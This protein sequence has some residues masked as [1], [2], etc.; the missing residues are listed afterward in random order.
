MNPTQRF[1]DR[2]ENYSRFRPSYPSQLIALLRDPQEVG[3]NATHVVADI[4]SGTGISSKLFLDNGNVVWGVEPNEKM[5]LGG[6]QFLQE[7]TEKGQFK[8]VAGT[9]ENTGL[10]ENGVDMVVAGQAF[11]WFKPEEATKEFQRILKKNSDPQLVANVVLFWNSRRTTETAF[12]QA[13][14][15]LIL[16]FSPDY[17]EVDHKNVTSRDTTALQRFFHHSKQQTFPYFQ[18]FDFDGFKGRLLSS[19]YAPNEHH[20]NYAPMMKELHHI[21]DQ[22]NVDGKIRFEYDTLVYYGTV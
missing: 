8:S 3:L 10:E 15:A 4:G 11:H 13:Y 20:V 7:Y 6:E 18:E 22:H 5:R 14:E 1:S 21:F 9:A 19:S 12:A 2:V 16:K 17:T